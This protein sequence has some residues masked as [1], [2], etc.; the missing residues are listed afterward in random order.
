MKDLTKQFSEAK[1]LIEKSEKVIITAHQRPDGDACGSVS[2]LS[3]IIAD[4]G[5]QVFPLLV[6]DFPE[7]INMLFGE[8]RPTVINSSV[9]NELWKKLPWKDADLIILTD[10]LHPDRA[11]GIE[12]LSDGRIPSIVFDHH[13]GDDSFGDVKVVDSSSPAAGEIVFRFAKFLGYKADKQFALSLFA[14]MATDTGWFRY[15]KNL[16]SAYKAAGELLAAGVDTEELFSV[17]YERESLA[18][19][20]LT[21]RML[22]SLK[23]HGGAVV[24]GRITQ[25]DFRESGA[26]E[27]DTEGLINKLQALEGIQTTFLL[28]ERSPNEIKCSMRSKGDVIVREVAE[29]LGGG[30]HDLAAGVSFFC[31]FEEAERQILEKIEIQ[32][33]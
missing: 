17:I 4:M 31:G 13:L 15:G 18:K 3:K 6:D 14:A 30:G 22:D 29:A 28:I 24:S 8:H 1:E 5:K 16:Q 10:A 26:V 12:E 7:W 27:S 33:S 21:S 20:R 9:D 32:T 25:Q 2:A 11:P 19:M 23:L